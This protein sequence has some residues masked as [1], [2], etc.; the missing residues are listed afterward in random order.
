MSTP[1]RRRATPAELT[2][3]QRALYERITGGP[4]AA[5]PQHFA[6]TDAEGRLAGPFD[7]LL[8]SPAV[9]TALQ[10]VGAAVRYGS[11]L[12][13][14]VRELAILRVAGH[15]DCAFERSAHVAIGRAV[16]LSEPEIAAAAAGTQ[17]DL[18]DPAESAALAV[19]EA[20]VLRGDLGDEEYTRAVD[21]LG[22]RGVFE[23]TAL[24]GYYATLALQLRVFRADGEVTL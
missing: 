6:L 7:A 5:G 11:D 20:L 18:S 10:E 3:E 14:R 21:R 9:G 13:D 22:E 24:V 12:T 17:P 1:R 8:L 15:W 4:R 19:V 2:E 16:G 23:L